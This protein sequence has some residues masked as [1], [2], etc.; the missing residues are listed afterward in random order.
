MG[1]KNEPKTPRAP[2]PQV[3]ADAQAQANR[4]AIY[5][6]ARVNRYDQYT[7]YGSVTWDRPSSDPST[8]TQNV[9]LSPEYQQRFQNENDL[10]L[11]VG[12][13]ANRQAGFLPNDQFS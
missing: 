6:S 7:P 1:S 4:Q 13:A 10:A 5:D 8:W 2:D 11:A 3:T 12:G 9:N